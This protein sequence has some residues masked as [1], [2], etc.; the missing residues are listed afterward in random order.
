MTN[1]APPVP[2]PA[3]LRL[4]PYGPGRPGPQ[5]ARRPLKRNSLALSRLRGQAVLHGKTGRLGLRN[6]P[7]GKPGRPVSPRTAAVAATWGQP[8]CPLSQSIT[9]AGARPAA[10]SARMK[11]MQGAT[12]AK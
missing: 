2:A 1:R 7:P 8:P 11:S 5:A 10:S 6:R 12:W 3:R 4:R 9:P